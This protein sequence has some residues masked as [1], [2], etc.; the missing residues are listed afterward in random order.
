[1]QSAERDAPILHE[2]RC[3]QRLMR[4]TSRAEAYER[5]CRALGGACRC[6]LGAWRAESQSSASRFC[7]AGVEWF[8]PLSKRPTQPTVPASGASLWCPEGASFEASST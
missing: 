2:W 7:V 6:R 5:I 1:M 4:R 8:G 3:E